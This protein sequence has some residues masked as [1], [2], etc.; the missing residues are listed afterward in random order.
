MA[1]RRCP[2]PRCPHLT[3]TRYCK[4][5]QREYEQRRG[6]SRERGYNKQ[7]ER[8]RKLW[9]AR[10]RRGEQLYCARCGGPIGQHEP[11]DLGHDDDDR[12]IY[13]GPE[14]QRCNRA[15]GGKSGARIR[16]ETPGG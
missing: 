14:H 10:Q 2:A 5:H 1:L 7:H 4:Q 12:N 9:R 11:F 16:N 13:N 8:L 15:A 3:A 6:S